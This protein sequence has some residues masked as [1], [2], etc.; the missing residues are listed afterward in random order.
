MLNIYLKC[1]CVIFNN[2]LSS[3]LVYYLAPFLSTMQASYSLT[4]MGDT[5]RLSPC[6]RTRPTLLWVLCD[7]ENCDDWSGSDRVPTA[8]VRTRNWLMTLGFYMKCDL[9]SICVR[10][11]LYL[12][13][14]YLKNTVL[15]T[16]S[17]DEVM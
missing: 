17:Y 16:T 3:H 8:G 12:C 13:F 1:G 14:L 7:T 5:Q 2:I 4:F 15:N 10:Q 6:G 9:R 11:N